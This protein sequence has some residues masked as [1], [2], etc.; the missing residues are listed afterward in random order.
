MTRTATSIIGCVFVFLLSQTAIG[1][2]LSVQRLDSINADPGA[3]QT[4][5]QQ[6]YQLILKDGGLLE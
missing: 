4:V 6:V 2:E 5:V 3:G 1:E